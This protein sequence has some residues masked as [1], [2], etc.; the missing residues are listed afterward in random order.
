[1]AVSKF[2]LVSDYIGSPLI[3]TYIPLN[4]KMSKIVRV[5]NRLEKLI[6]SRSDWMDVYIITEISNFK[7]ISKLDYELLLQYDG[8]HRHRI[9]LFKWTRLEKLK[10]EFGLPGWVN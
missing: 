9:N 1:M 2:E 6:L 8:S 4:N 5:L 3:I 10:T 7:K